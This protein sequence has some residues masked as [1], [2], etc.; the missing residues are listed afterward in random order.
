M[1]KEKKKK[2]RRDHT[3]EVQE[4]EAVK[5]VEEEPVKVKKKKKKAKNPEDDEPIQ[6]LSEQTSAFALT[7]VEGV[8][9]INYQAD[10]SR[11]PQ[12]TKFSN[13]IS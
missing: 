6:R 12:E 3:P 8:T 11:I 2:K 5:T 1:P 9:P 4:I 13:M 10:S 7:E